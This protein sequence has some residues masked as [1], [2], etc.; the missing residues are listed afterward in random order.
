MAPGS[1]RY[2]RQSCCSAVL[3]LVDWFYELRYVQRCYMISMLSPYFTEKEQIRNLNVSPSHY[4]S[5]SVWNSSTEQ[6]FLHDRN[7]MCTAFTHYKCEDVCGACRGNSAPWS[8][9]WA[10]SAQHHGSAHVQWMVMT[11][12]GDSGNLVHHFGSRVEAVRSW[13]CYRGSF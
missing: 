10:S 5:S 1:V 8:Q 6:W 11:F 2:F 9:W 13:R 7:I 4:H 3:L 12:L